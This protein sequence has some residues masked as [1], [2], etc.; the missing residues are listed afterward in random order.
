MRRVHLVGIG[1]AGMSALARL[2]LQLGLSVSGSDETDSPALHDL[3]RLGAT[4]YVGHDAARV[5]GADLV[6]YSS[7]IPPSN[8][9]LREAWR[10]G[11]RTLKHAPALA[12]LFHRKR[13]IAVAGTHGKTTT[14]SM[15][16]FVLER[17]GLD[18]AFQV[19]GELVDL[20]TSARWGDGPW[21][22]IEADEFDRRFLAYR[23]EIAVVTNVEPDHFECYGTVDALHDAFHAFLHR[24]RP[25]GTI[26]A[27]GQDPQLGHLLEQVE[28]RTV[29]RYGMAG[30]AAPAGSVGAGEVEDVALDWL[31]TNVEEV[32]GGTRFTVV[33]PEAAGQPFDAALQLPGR[34]HV[35]NALA[36]LAVCARA[37]V[38]PAPAGAILAGFRGVRRRFQLAG[39]AAGVRV[40]DD[41]GHH[42]T[43]VRVNLD[44]ARRLLPRRGRLW[45]VFQP[46]LRVRTDRL[47]DEFAC[48]FD[49]ADYVLLTDVYSP[50]GREPV[51][52]YRGSAELVDAIRARGHRGARH[53]PDAAEARRVLQQELRPG[54][55]VLVMGA[56][57]INLL[58]TELVAALEEASRAG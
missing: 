14:T 45:V 18:P 57:P 1:G 16:A 9:E 23:P 53:V 15:I 38:P 46:H 25:G 28:G 24:V 37:G 26:V 41:Y 39:A 10:R 36:A 3:A 47:F 32:P 58:A 31:A 35:L 40:Y 56:G 49:A 6:V 21:M 33:P 11:I 2:Y 5:A 34:H 20:D 7:A 43:E 51:G 29:V 30:G 42:P 19:G 44:A 48:A 52:P 12:E 55:V 13:G 54:D 22:V 17:A 50:S 27:W 4:V 8:P